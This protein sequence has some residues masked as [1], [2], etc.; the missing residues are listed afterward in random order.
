M[1]DAVKSKIAAVT[2]AAKHSTWKYFGA[3]FMEQKDGVQAVSLTRMLA[4]ICF[5]MM[6][7]KWGGLGDPVEV[8]ESLLWTF[9]GLIGGKTAESMISLW[10]GTKGQ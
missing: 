7:W 3:T 4:L 10:R 2:Q 5:G 8:P 1:T 6:V 9:W